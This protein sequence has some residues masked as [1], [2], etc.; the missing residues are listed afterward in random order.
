MLTMPS[1][2]T[3]ISAAIGSVERL[4]NISGGEQTVYVR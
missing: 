4:Q 2:D 3:R 1:K